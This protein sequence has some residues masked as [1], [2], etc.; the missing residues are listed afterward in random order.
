[1]TVHQVP[2]AHLA[3]R[4]S[5]PLSVLAFVTAAAVAVFVPEF[6]VAGVEKKVYLYYTVG[7]PAVGI[8]TCA[9]IAF[10]VT[11]QRSVLTR[12]F[13]LPPFD[14]LGR[15][16]YGMYLWHYPIILVIQVRLHPDPNITLLLALPLTVAAA[17]V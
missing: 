10:L 15:V 2:G 5:H 9:L 4:H 12:I 6:N 16:S 14:Y 8:A 13:S 7:Q 1:M 3:P 11:H 17:T